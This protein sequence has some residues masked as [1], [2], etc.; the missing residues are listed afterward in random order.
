V[1]RVLLR[2]N[3]A[4]GVHA[5]IICAYPETFTNP[6]RIPESF[7][8]GIRVFDRKPYLRRPVPWGHEQA[9]TPAT[10]LPVK[11]LDTVRPARVPSLEGAFSRP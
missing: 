1:Y 6:D 10:V 2:I 4:D 11:R 8:H 5:D 9:T 7:R 3:I